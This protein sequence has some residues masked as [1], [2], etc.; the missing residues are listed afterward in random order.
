MAQFPSNCYPQRHQKIAL[1][2]TYISSFEFTSIRATVGSPE[3][4]NGRRVRAI[5]CRLYELGS[6]AGRLNLVL[7]IRRR[8]RTSSSVW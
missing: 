3:P 2:E 4:E 5:C 8:I 1:D 6:K 7:S